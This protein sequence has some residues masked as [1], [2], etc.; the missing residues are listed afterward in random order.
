M[1]WVRNME[2]ITSTTLLE[3][4]ESTDNTSAWQLLYEHFKPMLIG[5]AG[6][7]GLPQHLCEDASHEAIQR[8]YIALRAGKYVKEK[9]RLNRWL[10]GISRRVMLNMRRE[11][12][13]EQLIS[14]NQ[15]GTYFWDQIEDKNVVMSLTSHTIQ[16]A[17]GKTQTQR[18]SCVTPTVK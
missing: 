14:A 7:L 2:W 1:E 5:L 12:P 16:L 13:R 18:D 6:K 8:F 9:G 11:L 10:F 15:T 3:D 17:S 4:L